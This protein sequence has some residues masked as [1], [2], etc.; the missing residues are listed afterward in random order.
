MMRIVP[1]SPCVASKRDV[2][3]IKL[4]I[5]AKLVSFLTE[6]ENLIKQ[7]PDATSSSDSDPDFSPSPRPQ[8]CEQRPSRG[9]TPRT[10]ISPPTSGARAE[11]SREVLLHELREET[12]QGAG[13]QEGDRDPL[14]EGG[15]PARRPAA[16][17]LP[18]VGV[19]DE[20]QGHRLRRLLQGRG[21]PAGRAGAQ[22][23]DRHLL[24]AGEGTLQM[25]QG[26][27]LYDRLRQFFQLDASE[28]DLLQDQDK[29]SGRSRRLTPPV[30]PSAL[31]S[32]IN[33]SSYVYDGLLRAQQS[34]T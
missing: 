28:R 24:R 3:V 4:N 26:G 15:S 31:D 20:E 11:S 25:P 8:T 14:L 16:G 2:N 34:A 32:S 17:L 19:R 12:V 6:N 13:R 27:H 7:Q 1:N 33:V 22:A 5:K 21:C 18:R 29:E 9:A 10:L 23:E 30:F